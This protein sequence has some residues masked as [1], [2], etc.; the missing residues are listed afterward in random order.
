MCIRDSGCTFSFLEHGMQRYGVDVSFID[1]SNLDEVRAA[2]RPETS[3][4]YIETPA[5]PT[6]KIEDIAGICEIAHSDG[7]SITVMCDNTFASPYNQLPIEL[8][9]DVVAVSYTHLDVYKRQVLL[10]SILPTASCS[11]LTATTSP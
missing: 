4:I 2:I 1:T 3:L 5:N 10:T 11:T 8:G 7:R 6:L 9:C